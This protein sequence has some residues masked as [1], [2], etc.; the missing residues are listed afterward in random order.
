M[1][2]TLTHERLLSVLHYDP[3]TGIFTWISPA[4]QRVKQGDVAGSIS[5]SGYRRIRIDGEMYRASHLVWLYVH[6]RWPRSA[7]MDHKDGNTLN[8][9]LSNLRMA[10]AST[11]SINSKPKKKASDTKPGVE[12]RDRSGVVTYRARI[13]WA[14][15]LQHL[16]T[17]STEDDAYAAY[18]EAKKVLHR[19]FLR[20]S[21]LPT[22]PPNVPQTRTG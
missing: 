11:N 14:G 22:I 4:S 1:T 2:K 15:K 3:E 18:V 10:S 12:R 17:F 7:R 8:D 20:W 13:K 6:G 5:E 21:E 9:R 19:E 16:G